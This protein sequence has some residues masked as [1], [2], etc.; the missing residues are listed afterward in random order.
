M[1]KNK[2]CLMR[3]LLNQMKVKTRFFLIFMLAMLPILLCVLTTLRIPYATYDRRLYD[4]SVQTITL[5][6]DR[7]Q[8]ELNEIEGLSYRV[9]SDNVLQ[10]NLSV[11]RKTPIGTT[12]WIDAKDEVADR[13]ANF[14][15]WFT[16]SSG[17]SIQLKTAGG[18]L[19][20]Q[21][22]RSYHPS[23]ELTPGRLSYAAGHQGR[24]V[25]LSE[26]SDPA[27]LFLL[28]EIREIEGLSLQ[29]LATLLVEMDLS[30]LVE[31]QRGEMADMG[32]PLSCAIYDG[33]VCLYASDDDV[34]ATA[35]GEDGYEYERLNGG[36]RLCVRYTAGNGWQYVTLIDYT[37]IDQAVNAA[38][39][40]VLIIDLLVMA[41]ALAL[42]MVLI[43]SVLKH[44]AELL[45]K[46]DAFALHGYVEG[47]E[48]SAYAQRGDE[49][50]Q[51]HRHFDKMTRDY[52]QMMQRSWEQQQLLQEAQMQQLRAQVRPHFLYNTLEAIY[53]LAQQAGE[54][55]IATMT[56]ALGKM[57]RASLNDKRDVVTVGEDL[58]VAREYLR[59][60]Q[61]RYGE[62]FRAEVDVPDEMTALKIP[63]MTIQ[64]LVENAVHY[65]LEEMLDVCVIRIAARS[66]PDGA[67]VTVEDNGPGM[68][69]DIL[70]KLENGE[71]KPE[72]LGIGLRNI[73]RRVRYTFGERYGVRVRRREG[74]TCVAVFLP[75]IRALPQGGDDR[76]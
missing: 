8:S 62:H 23:D 70:S 73:D 72:G 5:F 39:D 14:A 18:T 16:S 36:S 24:S 64:P 28:R 15:L 65:A 46:F 59:I 52:H 51:L 74:K 71:I 6:A 26:G 19:F 56:D 63:A 33:S 27:R 48:P 30:G 35:A 10:K 2:T 11:M 47:D 41:A 43:Q 38:A 76:V 22:F 66:L 25:W 32:S 17:V 29:T 12:D 40:R 55:R 34:R 61:I 49:I 37:Q 53:C 44:L 75:D 69:E 13:V 45:K 9:L 31:K 57:L 1:E 60:Q 68:D 21:F 50:G 3:R 67:E 7:I 54:S 4:N 20:S 58:Q 42:A